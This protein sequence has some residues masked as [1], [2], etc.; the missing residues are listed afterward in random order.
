MT[1]RLTKPGTAPAEPEQLSLHPSS[2]PASVSAAKPRPKKRRRVGQIEPQA[3]AE[4]HE[5]VVIGVAGAFALAPA[6]MRPTRSEIDA[7]F[8][9]AERIIL[10][11]VSLDGPLNPDV[12][13]AIMLFGGLLGYGSRVYYA[14]DGRRRAAGQ[15]LRAVT[16]SGGSYQQ[17]GHSAG[18][19]DSVSASSA[20]GHTNGSAGN[21]RTASDI[22]ATLY[23]QTAVPPATDS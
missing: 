8:Q 20:A 11:R 12:V 21:W 13:D 9:P 7:I 14:S 22:L 17:A 5:V 18:A 2:D 15:P 6:H 23:E 16:P 19:A 10:R 1:R 4:L 3:L